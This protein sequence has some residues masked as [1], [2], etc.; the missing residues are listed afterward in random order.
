MELPSETWRHT[1]GDCGISVARP[2]RLID[3]SRAPC[4][5]SHASRGGA[6]QRCKAV[7]VLS[8]GRP[9]ERGGARMRRR[10]ARA[11]RGISKTSPVSLLDGGSVPDS[12]ESTA[13]H[14]VHTSAEITQLQGRASLTHEYMR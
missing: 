14:V 8:K 13:W 6:S 3:S 7:T 9:T 1:L 11:Q 10:R 4:T 5:T 2:S 12:P